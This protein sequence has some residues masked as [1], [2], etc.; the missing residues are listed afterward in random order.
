MVLKM[1]QQSTLLIIVIQFVLVGCSSNP[2][3]CCGRPVLSPSAL[4]IEVR[5]IRAL[6][7]GWSCTL[8]LRPD[9]VPTTLSRFDVLLELLRYQFT[10]PSGTHWEFSRPPGPV[11]PAP[12]AADT[13]YVS[14]EGVLAD[15]Y[16]PFGVKLIRS[17]GVTAVYPENLSY[18]EEG[19]LD[20]A[21]ALP[22]R[23]KGMA[24]VLT[25]R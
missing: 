24:S 23:S 12:A 10:D 5:E 6:E 20:S 8:F 15:F 2:V 21:R 13:L 4:Q 11:S 18:S 3:G 22:Y 19:F 1:A 16:L 17:D 9:E 14:A 25:S 7:G